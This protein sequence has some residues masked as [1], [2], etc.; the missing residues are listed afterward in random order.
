M[1]PS[2][3]TFALCLRRVILKDGQLPLVKTFFMIRHGESKWNEAQSKINIPG[4]FDR[5]HPLTEEGK[6]MFR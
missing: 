1:H 5:D 6:C 4:M 2:K 3:P